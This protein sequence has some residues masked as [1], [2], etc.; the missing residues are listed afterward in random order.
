[1]LRD[2][3]DALPRSWFLLNAIILAIVGVSFLEYQVITTDQPPDYLLSFIVV[4]VGIAALWL[5]LQIA[6]F[7]QRFLQAVT[8]SAGTGLILSVVSIVSFLALLPLLGLQGAFASRL[9]VL[10]W[11]L[12]V[13]GHII[14]RAIDQHLAVGV[15]IATAIFIG[16]LVIFSVFGVTSQ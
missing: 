11:S 14:A 3:P 7:P 13:D 4:L 6:G 1:M 15:A 12:A 8:A 2:G 10:F 9:V 16:Q 5:V